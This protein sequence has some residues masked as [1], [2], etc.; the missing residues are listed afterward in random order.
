MSYKLSIADIDIKK[1][2]GSM[3]SAKILRSGGMS[4]EQVQLLEKLQNEKIGYVEK[5]TSGNSTT[6]SFY[7][8]PQKEHL[9]LSINETNPISSD[10]TSAQKTSLKKVANVATMPMDKVE[11]V[12]KV[13]GTTE[14]GAGWIDVTSGG[15]CT[16]ITPQQYGAFGDGVHDDTASIQL[17]IDSLKDKGGCL[18][19]PNGTYLINT[20]DVDM[21]SIG[22][23]GKSAIR[24]YS[25]VKVCGDTKSVIKVADGVN[26][27]DFCFQAVFIG[28]VI[29][30]ICIE[31]II[32][33]LNGSNNHLPSRFNTESDDYACAGILTTYP[34]KITVKS[35]TFKGSSGLNSLSLGYVNGAIVRDCIFENVADTIDGNTVRDHSSIYIK[36][37]DIVVSS[38]RLVNNSVVSEVATA[39]EVDGRNVRIDS[40]YVKNYSQACIISPVGG[41]DAICN[42]VTNNTFEDNRYSI[43]LWSLTNGKICENVVVSNNTVKGLSWNVNGRWDCDLYT[44]VSQPVKNVIITDNVFYMD[45]KEPENNYHGCI[46]IG[47][48]TDGVDIKNNIVRGYTGEALTIFGGAKNTTVCGNSFIECC[49]TLYDIASPIIVNGEG[50]IVVGTVIDSNKVDARGHFG[51]AMVGHISNT[52]IVQNEIVG[53]KEDFHFDSAILDGDSGNE[54]YI[55][56]SSH[57]QLIGVSIYASYGSEIYSSQNN[58][59]FIKN[60]PVTESAWNTIDYA[61]KYPVGVTEKHIKGDIV[62]NTKPSASSDFAWVCIA[63]GFPGT[64]KG[65]SIDNSVSTGDIQK[66]IQEELEVTGFIRSKNRL[67][68]AEFT[69]LLNLEYVDGVFRS[70]VADT[71][72]FLYI[73][74]QS[75]NGVEYTT[76]FNMDIHSSGRYYHSFELPN[77]SRYFLL[78]HNGISKD[79]YAQFDSSLIRKTTCTVS[80]DVYKF[81]P[82]VVGG[83]E[84]GNIQIEFGDSPTDFTPFGDTI[85]DDVNKIYH[86]SHDSKSLNYVIRTTERQ[87]LDDFTNVTYATGYAVFEYDLTNAPYSNVKLDV[88]NPFKFAFYSSNEDVSKDTLISGAVSDAGE[89]IAQIPENAKYLMVSCL[90]ESFRSVK[91][92]YS[93][94]GEET[95]REEGMLIDLSDIVSFMSTMMADA[96]IMNTVDLATLIWSRNASYPV[97]EA[98][99]SSDMQGVTSNYSSFLCYHKNYKSGKISGTLWNAANNINSIVCSSDGHLYVSSVDKPSGVLFYKI[100]AE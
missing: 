96:K 84:I 49:N 85:V 69:K 67:N 52:R 19:F 31:N 75:Y 17:A 42:I 78:R 81:N 83:V 95:K 20:F 37:N 57:K 66:N 32:F 65:I 64:W 10:F 24:L 34:T 93:T 79:F 58:K 73:E 13:W 100:K 90:K 11:P 99:A 23:Q 25:N 48:N 71:R 39:I 51:I 77:N 62:Y 35:C 45:A 14:N 80:F 44:F 38:N 1:P 16:I 70:T 76:L 60:T 53:S 56:H 94:T 97:W 41:S 4:E 88:Q 27:S 2:D 30:N 98:T 29:S 3:A 63:D 18:F 9:I 89:R 43:E 12:G 55:Q 21:S 6:T 15:T 68:Q 87:L 40:N 28:H 86:V 47:K 82:S 46:A 7:D 33:D 8:S 61:N 5:T 92:T 26:N 36:G 22:V 91:N 72:T 50:D 59:R 54:I 74:C